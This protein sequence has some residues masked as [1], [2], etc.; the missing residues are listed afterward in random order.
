[1]GIPYFHVLFL[2]LIRHFPTAFWMYVTKL[3]YQTSFPKFVFP[4]HFITNA[5]WRCCGLNSNYLSG[6]P[7]MP[8]KV[9]LLP[10]CFFSICYCCFPKSG[11]SFW[12]FD[13]CLTLPHFTGSKTTIMCTMSFLFLWVTISFC[14]LLEG[15]KEMS[16]WWVL[17]SRLDF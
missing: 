1:M 5:M 11:F 7:T 9:L 2:H 15:R 3:S 14:F 8:S 16:E 4:F 10:F 6:F 13:A 17:I 12:F